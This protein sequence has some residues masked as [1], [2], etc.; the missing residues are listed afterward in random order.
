MHTLMT[1]GTTY[2]GE[3]VGLG[4][5]SPLQFA[6]FLL[7]SAT[8]DHLPLS[9]SLAHVLHVDQRPDSLT[10]HEFV[11]RTGSRGF[12]LMVVLL[13]LPL[14]VPISVPG[15]STLIGSVIGLLALRAAIGKSAH[16]PAFL[17]RRTVS[18]EFQDKMLGGSIRVLRLLEK[19]TR[20]RQTYWLKWPITRCINACLIAFMALLLALPVPLPFS[21]PL[22][23]CA[24]ILLSV[25]MMEEDGVLI[26]FG[27]GLAAG[28]V[29]F[30]AFFSSVVF[31]LLRSAA[32]LASG[33]F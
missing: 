26:W 3:G 15:F 8:M 12:H 9:Q 10:L 14:V 29:S 17:G 19:V 20:R 33:W 27:Y 2:A 16:L 5:L 23:S 1:L 18:R 11:E 6:S 28:S 13:A 22:P 31:A 30:F 25:S 32:A 4:R 21:N 7:L 24:V